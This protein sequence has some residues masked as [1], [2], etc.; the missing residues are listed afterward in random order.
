VQLKSVMF[1]CND[2][3][4]LVYVM[5]NRV[6]LCYVFL[7]GRK[8]PCLEVVIMKRVICIFAVSETLLSGACM[9]PEDAS[10]R[11]EIPLLGPLT[12]E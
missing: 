9:K 10:S 12:A 11:G 5:L 7:N 2:F 4:S 6:S 3:Q 8:Q 1:R